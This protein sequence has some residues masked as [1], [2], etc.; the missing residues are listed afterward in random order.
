[1]YDESKTHKLLDH[2]ELVPIE[3][4]ALDTDPSIP[5]DNDLPTIDSKC[6]KAPSQAKQKSAFEKMMRRRAERYGN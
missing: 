1:M 4:D 3:E 6:R 5:I 2:D